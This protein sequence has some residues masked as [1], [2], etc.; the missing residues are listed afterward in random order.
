MNLLL[1]AVAAQDRLTGDPEHIRSTA[2]E[3]LARPEFQLD[4]SSG[5][6][7]GLAELILR[8]IFKLLRPIF[9]FFGALWDISPALAWLTAI[10]LSLVLVLLLA[11]IIYTLRKV[12]AQ[13][14][15][16]YVTAQRERSKSYEQYQREATDAAARGD[17]ITAVR[18]LFRASLVRLEQA[19][20]RPVRPGT[21]NRELL[22]RYQQ[23]GL[24]EH[25]QR[26]VEVIDT[27]WYAGSTCSESDY[28]NCLQAHSRLVALAGG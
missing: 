26:F 14:L 13:R 22:R 25:L 11:H 16:T 21:T 7:G 1:A 28:Q 8:L 9:R 19:E 23:S 4:R 10:V 24:A 12:L 5:E 27:R 18:L 20:K 3:V 17:Y 15:P 2:R 6:T